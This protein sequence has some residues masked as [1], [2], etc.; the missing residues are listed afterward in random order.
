MALITVEL[1]GRVS[2]KLYRVKS[3][4]LGNQVN[5][6]SDLAYFNYLNRKVN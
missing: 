2:F 5:S 4:N 3:G 6:D 1:P